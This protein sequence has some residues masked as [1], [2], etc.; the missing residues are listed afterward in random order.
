MENGQNVDFTQED[1]NIPLNLAE[2]EVEYN[3]SG[4]NSFV[5]LFSIRGQIVSEHETN[6]FINALAEEANKGPLAILIEIDTPGGRVDLAKQMCAAIDE[7]RGCKTIAYIKGGENGGAFSAGAAISLACDEIYMSPQTTIGAATMLASTRSGYVL[8]M[9]RAYGEAVGEKY[10]AAWRSYLASL[11]EKNNRSGAL[12]KAMADKDIE[13]VE[14]SRGGAQLFV[15]PSDKRPDDKVIGTVCKKG[16]LLAMPANK[17]LACKISD[18]TAESRQEI[19]R[20]SCRER[21]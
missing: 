9:K 19:G 6:A 10:N 20:A 3:F 1:G 5:S 12:A 7:I 11:A 8:D 21:V 16:E 18:G 4:R 17:A 15:E 13:V 2:Y 14:I